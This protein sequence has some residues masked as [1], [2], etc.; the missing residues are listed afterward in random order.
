MQPTLNIIAPLSRIL[1]FPL[2]EALPTDLKAVAEMMPG[3]VDSEVLTAELEVS[4][5]I[6]SNSQ[7]RTKWRVETELSNLSMISV[8]SYF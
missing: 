3:N 6:L 4:A 8:L 7:V 5:N 2:N 1:Q